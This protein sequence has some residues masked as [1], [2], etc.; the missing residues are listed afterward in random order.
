MTKTVAIVGA[1]LAGLCCARALSRAGVDCVVLEADDRVG[2]RV[3]TLREPFEDDQYA[4][5]GG[6]FVDTSHTELLALIDQL[7]LE[8]EEAGT[9]A[10][11]ELLVHR[12]GE[13]VFQTG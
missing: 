4:D 1:G 2:G 7:G 10:P 11:V 3:F 6:E 13:T 8:V 9:E 12:D 5:A